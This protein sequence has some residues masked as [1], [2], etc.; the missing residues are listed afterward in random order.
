VAISNDG[1]IDTAFGT[2]VEVDDSW[3][4]NSDV[5]RS[6]VS[7][8]V[9][10]GNTPAEGDLVFFNL[11]RKVGDCN[12]DLTGDARVLGIKIIYTRNSYGD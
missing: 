11:A 7:G 1:A 2:E 4:A 5:H 6:P 3:I 8:A 10:I 9:T 12:D